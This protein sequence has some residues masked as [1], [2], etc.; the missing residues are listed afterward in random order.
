MKIGVTGANGLVGRHVCRALTRAGHAVVALVRDPAKSAG[1][2]IV[3]TRVLPTLGASMDKAA[4]AGA[5]SGLEAVVHLA[6]HVHVMKSAPDPAVFDAVNVAGSLAVLDAAI[7]AGAKRFVFMSS[8]KAAGERSDGTPLSTDMAPAPEDAYGRSKLAAERALTERAAGWNGRLVILRPTFVYGWPTTGN[9]RTVVNAVRKGVPLPLAAIRN[10]RDMAYAGNLADAVRAALASET[11]G[12]GP[13]FICDGDPVSTPELFRRTAT[14]F[15]GRARLFPV[16]G[17]ALKLAGA[18][19]GRGA[20]VAR[21]RGDFRVDGSPFRRDAGW[22]PPYKMSE[23][24]SEAAALA[25]NDG[26]WERT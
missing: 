20:A 17:W 15:A 18:L 26:D 8:V 7:A 6:A 2:D 21:L 13:Y 25:A 14:A 11:V 3:E 19:T 23:G 9:F 12:A 22:Q 24:L 4:L 1:L 10:R 5:L 16:P